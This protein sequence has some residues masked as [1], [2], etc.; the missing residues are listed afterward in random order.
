MSTSLNPSSSEAPCVKSLL[1]ELAESRRLVDF[2]ALLPCASL[3]SWLP[4]GCNSCSS[5]KVVI[6]YF[7]PRTLRRVLD[8][9]IKPTPSPSGEILQYLSSLSARFCTVSASISRG[10]LRFASTALS[11]LMLTPYTRDRSTTSATL[12]TNLGPCT[13]S[14][15]ARMLN[16]YRF[17]SVLSIVI[18]ASSGGISPDISFKNAA[19]T[20]INSGSAAPCKR[21]TM[22]ALSTLSLL[23][24][25]PK[26]LCSNAHRSRSLKPLKQRT[27]RNLS[28][29]MEG[30][31]SRSSRG[32]GLVP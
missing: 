5:S 24:S 29:L 20:H 9:R 6:L 27:K 16:S 19:A 8:L 11:C 23:A 22:R 18:T 7:R 30:N 31:T 21:H 13:I 14:S 25:E 17:S 1:S 3:S 10:L 28:V 2:V 4:A 15:Q 12:A 26:R 32:R